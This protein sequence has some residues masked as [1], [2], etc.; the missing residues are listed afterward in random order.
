LFTESLESRQLLATFTADF[1]DL[2]LAPNSE[3]VGPD[4][5]GQTVTEDT[6]FGSVEERRGSFTTG[7]ATLSNRYNLSWSSWGAFAYSNHTDNTTP[8]FGNQYSSFAGSGLGDAKYGVAFMDVSGTNPAV[9]DQLPHITVPQGTAIDDVSITNTTYAALSMRDGDSFAKKFGGNTGNDPDWFKVT[10]YGVDGSG[11]RLAN[12]AEFYLADYR[13]A[14]N[15]EDYIVQDW[16][17]FDLSPLAG[18]RTVYFA[19]S[20]SD[21]GSNGINTP[22]YFAIDDIHYSNFGPNHAPVLDTS[23]T[24]TLPNIAEDT[25]NPAGVSVSSLVQGRVTD[26]DFAAQ[27]G[28]AVVAAGN[29]NG[30]WQYSLNGSD[31]L[32]LGSVSSAAARLLPDTAKIRLVPKANFNGSMTFNFRAW[33]Q[34]QGVA[35][36]LF[37]L[38]TKTG[39]PN[40]FSIAVETTS[41][42]VTPVNDAPL[43]NATAT[44]SFGTIAEDTPAGSIPG[45][46]VASLVAGKTTDVDG[47]KIGVAI[48]GLGNPG[49]GTYQFSSN[50]GASWTTISTTSD[51][52]ALLL[53]PSDRVRFVPNRDFNGMVD[54]YYRAW[55]Q[56]QG[57]AHTFVSLSGQITPTGAF[58]ASFAKSS[59][60]ITPVNDAPQVILGGSLGYVRGSSPV[61]LA[62]AGSVRDVDNVTLG[63][64]QLRVRIAEGSTASDVLS[65][66]GGFTVDANSDV[67]QGT[68]KL[69]KRTSDGVGGNELVVLFESTTTVDQAQALLRSVSFSTSAN[70]SVGARKVLFS[71]SDGADSSPEVA[72][73]VNVR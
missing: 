13:F 1:S 58:S 64:G 15:S 5:N 8:G 11:N 6:Q 50:A 24:P 46:T 32:S 56:S 25:T 59:A 63:G 55:D 57:A 51:T 43:L 39:D 30:T 7:G 35:G 37:D 45:V 41:Q 29:A 40:A 9:F 2:S 28:I 20:S 48:I 31:W 73:T 34:T 27:R 38:R 26:A 44:P 70:A 54:L 21:T 19:L 65:F 49:R 10:A 69:G 68:T 66:G 60:T 53:L 42:T 52:N 36:E 4:P 61:V 67:W 62:P 14:D 23:G 12:T 47:D 17:K 33:D 18:A 16:Q 72:K 71:V 3:W 22:T